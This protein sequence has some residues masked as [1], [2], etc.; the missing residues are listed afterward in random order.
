MDKLKVYPLMLPTHDESPLY[1]AGL[2]PKIYIGR[3]GSRAVSGNQ[4]LYLV[5]DREIG[6]YEWFYAS[7]RK[8]IH[9]NEWNDAASLKKEFFWYKK[10]EATTDHSLN[11]PLI[12]NSFIKEWVEKQGKIEKVYL[13]IFEDGTLK[14]YYFDN[15][16]STAP[17]DL[18]EV[19]ILSVKESWNRQEL[20]SIARIAWNMNPINSFDEWFDKNY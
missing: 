4:H 20:K 5:S 6:K 2:V 7:D 14:G 10:I 8:S 1:I 16:N 13:D 12:P 17:L 18:M 11:F 19:I 15:S 9:K 3:V